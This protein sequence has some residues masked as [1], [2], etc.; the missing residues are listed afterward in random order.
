ME[1]RR[2]LHQYMII[3]WVFTVDT[4]PRR[5]S[6]PAPAAYSGVWAGGQRDRGQFG[7]F[8]SSAE[9]TSRSRK[10]CFM[11]SFSGL[12]FLIHFSSSFNFSLTKYRARFIGPRV[13]T[14]HGVWHIGGLFM[15]SWRPFY[16]KLRY[17]YNTNGVLIL[18]NTN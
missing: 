8:S 7:H 11:L 4:S 17:L 14:L 9:H 15:P 16:V 5:P 10:G 13:C 6:L 18:I 1:Y 12:L 2:P 3:R